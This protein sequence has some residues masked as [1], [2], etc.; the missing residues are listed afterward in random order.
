M[1]CVLGI[2]PNEHQIP[3]FLWKY[4]NHTDHSENTE[5]SN[6]PNVFPMSRVTV[7]VW[8]SSVSMSLNGVSQGNRE[9]QRDL[10]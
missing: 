7:G 1:G 4:T 10:E 2:E 8:D 9:E 5:K 6:S 3:Y